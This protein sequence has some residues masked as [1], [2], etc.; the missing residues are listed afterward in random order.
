MNTTES[1]ITSQPLQK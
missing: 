1:F